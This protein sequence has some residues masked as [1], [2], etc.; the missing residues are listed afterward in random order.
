[1]KEHN[2][3]EMANTKSV[4]RK[5]DIKNLSRNFINQDAISGWS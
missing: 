2:G 4:K 1:M 3:R 5:R